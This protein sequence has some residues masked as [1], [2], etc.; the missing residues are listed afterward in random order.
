VLPALSLPS[1]S[2]AGAGPDGDDGVSAKTAGGADAN[3][4]G[5]FQWISVARPEDAAAAAGSD[6]ENGRESARR[7][8]E[9]QS[10]QLGAEE[11]LPLLE[12]CAKEIKGRGAS[13][14]R[15]DRWL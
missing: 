8:E 3:S 6:G 1:A 7:R 14:H 10:A 15:S 11:L 12:L 4:V 9:R 13:S 5:S 2:L